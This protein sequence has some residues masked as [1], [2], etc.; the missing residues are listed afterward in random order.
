MKNR[1]TI[2]GIQYVR[3]DTLLT[4][5][6]VLRVKSVEPFYRENGEYL[7]LMFDMPFAKFNVG[8]EVVIHNLTKLRRL[9]K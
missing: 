4:T 3:E 7:R 2:E 6:E 9:K 5:D 1:I 8:D